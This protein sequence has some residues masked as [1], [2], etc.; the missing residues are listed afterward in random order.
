MPFNGG[1]KE[2]GSQGAMD[3]RLRNAVTKFHEAELRNSEIT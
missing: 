3:Q 2:R 1:E